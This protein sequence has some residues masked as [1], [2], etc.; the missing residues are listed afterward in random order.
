[1]PLK[2]PQ[3]ENARPTG[4]TDAGG[5]GDW[6]LIIAPRARATLTISS[7][8][9][10]PRSPR[11]VSELERKPKYFADNSAIWR[12]Q[13]DANPGTMF[14]AGVRPNNL[15]GHTVLF[16]CWTKASRDQGGEDHLAVRPMPVSV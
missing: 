12:C 16:Y 13:K 4:G 9:S 14:S 6:V 15:S 3:R 11:W 10:S 8:G 7:V 2:C 5:G 1:M